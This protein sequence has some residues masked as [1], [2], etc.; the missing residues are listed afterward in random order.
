MQI[1]SLRYTD[2]SCSFL[3][4]WQMCLESMCNS[5]KCNY[6]FSLASWAWLFAMTKFLCLFECLYLLK[7]NYWIKWICILGKQLRF[8]P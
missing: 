5:P 2:L 1:L 4:K 3:E 7:L 8:W 6:M